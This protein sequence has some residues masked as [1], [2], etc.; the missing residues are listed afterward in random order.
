NRLTHTD[1][2]EELVRDLLNRVAFGVI[3][4]LR[5]GGVFPVH[6]EQRRVVQRHGEDVELARVAKLLKLVGVH[7]GV[8]DRA[9]QQRLVLDSGVGQN[10][11]QDVGDTSR[12]AIPV[13]FVGA[14]ANVFAGSVFVNVVRAAG[15]RRRQVG[16]AVDK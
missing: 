16:F 3:G 9:A 4:R 7:E 13:G 10:L 6:D 5:A 14:Q 12:L 2:A 1:I 15:N 11:V 8:V